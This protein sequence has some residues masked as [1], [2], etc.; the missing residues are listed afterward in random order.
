MQVHC[1]DCVRLKLNTSP[2]YKFVIGSL[3]LVQD[4][5]RVL[6]EYRLVNSVC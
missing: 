3:G 1:T 4:D 2:K 6:L 5:G